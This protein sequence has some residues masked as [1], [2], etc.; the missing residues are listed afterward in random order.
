MSLVTRVALDDAPPVWY[1]YH[2]ALGRRRLLTTHMTYYSHDLVLSTVYCLLSTVYC[3]LSTVY[4][5]LS[6]VYCI[7]TTYYSPE[8][9]MAQVSGDGPARLLV[10]REHP[11]PEGDIVPV[12][13]AE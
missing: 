1:I 6:I 2:H 3:L 11:P 7:L 10:R 9:R 8:G 13:L 4:C 12:H 5:L